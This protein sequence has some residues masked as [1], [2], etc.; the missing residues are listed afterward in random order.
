MNKILCVQT[1]SNNFTPWFFL[2]ISNKKVSFSFL[3]FF[4]SLFKD[5]RVE[6]SRFVPLP[7]NLHSPTE[8]LNPRV[9]CPPPS[10]PRDGGCDGGRSSRCGRLHILVCVL[11]PLRQERVQVPM[12][13]H[14]RRG[15][16]EDA[17]EG[18]R[19]GRRQHAPHPH[20]QPLRRHRVRGIFV[21]Y[22]LV[23]SSL[24]CFGLSY[25]G[26]GFVIRM[27]CRF[28]GRPNFW[29]REAAWRTAWRWRLSRR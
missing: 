25:W 29:T 24:C 12:G 5:S 10:H 13:P 9:R 11:P 26:N 28:W 14:H 22:L 21:G 17:A 2:K 16:P 27:G 18:P 23:C 20:Q 15:R 6:P 3:I 8:L 4:N 19:G 1:S 7:L